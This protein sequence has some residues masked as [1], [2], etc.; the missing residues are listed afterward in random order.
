M[1]WYDLGV[2]NGAENKGAEEGGRKMAKSARKR[3]EAAGGTNAAEVPR[4]TTPN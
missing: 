2:M 4:S 1:A 3:T